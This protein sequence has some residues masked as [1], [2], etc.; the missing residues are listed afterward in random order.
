MGT[1]GDRG[2]R[3]RLSEFRETWENL[4]E[5]RR[6]P[7]RPRHRDAG[8]QAEETDTTA[9]T[10]FRHP[11]G[12]F[13]IYTTVEPVGQGVFSPLYFISHSFFTFFYHSKMPN[14]LPNNSAEQ[15]A[16]NIY[17]FYCII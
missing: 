10:E 14:I 9:F 17:W 15:R 4:D 5:Q 16:S 1:R 3:E 7:E 12:S 13:V 8:N 6:T 2:I 11:Y